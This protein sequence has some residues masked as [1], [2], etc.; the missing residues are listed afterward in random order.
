MKQVTLPVR[1]QERREYTNV[2]RLFCPHLKTIN[3]FNTHSVAG[4]L[5]GFVV[6]YIFFPSKSVIIV[7]N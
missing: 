4:R 5:G 7:H 2:N 6:T 1:F 3:K